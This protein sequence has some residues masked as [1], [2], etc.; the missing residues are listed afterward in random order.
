LS[1]LKNP[2]G[3]Y[4]VTTHGGSETPKIP[5]KAINQLL[6]ASRWTRRI[7]A[8]V[9]ALFVL[10]LA[11][12]IVMTILAAHGRD[13][14]ARERSRQAAASIL[15]AAKNRLGDIALDYAQSDESLAY[16][17]DQVDE[18]WAKA[19]IGTT[20]HRIY[21]IHHVLVFDRHDRIVF[22]SHDENTNP[23]ETAFADA[24]AQAELRCLVLAAR[25]AAAADPPT[26]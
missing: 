17:R 2:H 7:M 22:A 26:G 16:L 19:N 5:G 9:V 14:D 3:L 10:G 21:A 18:A 12:I 4:P 8:P 23:Q 15:T 25:A 11:G 20:P 6:S 1:W 13:E 24:D